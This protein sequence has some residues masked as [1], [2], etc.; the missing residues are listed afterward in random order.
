MDDQAA[1]K[2]SWMNIPTEKREINKETIDTQTPDLKTLGHV[3]SCDNGA[4]E[5][6]MLEL[7]RFPAVLGGQKHNG[8]YTLSSYTN[9]PSVPQMSVSVVAATDENLKVLQSGCL[10]I[11]L[12]WR[13]CDVSHHE[14]SLMAEWS[15]PSCRMLSAF[16]WSVFTCIIGPFVPFS[17]CVCEWVLTES[18][19]KMADVLACVH[20]I[21]VQL[22]HW[23]LLEL[24]NTR[25][26]ILSSCVKT[27]EEGDSSSIMEGL[28]LWI[29]CTGLR[30]S[31]EL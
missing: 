10:L 12:K 23:F 31:N 3:F 24:F 15:S 7:K 29:G 1:T 16:F 27:L 25:T 18:L 8:T 28:T 11:T 26:D 30:G 5:E 6:K 17:M 21:N 13:N 9:R 4:L 20:P 14:S 19:S 22:H 2:P